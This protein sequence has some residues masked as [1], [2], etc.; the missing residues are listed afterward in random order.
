MILS[1]FVL[2]YFKIHTVEHCIRSAVNPVAE[3]NQTTMLADNFVD[4][5]MI[6]PHNNIMYFRMGGGICTRERPD[7]VRK[8]FSLAFVATAAATAP[9][10]GEPD[11][12]ARMNAGIKT[13]A[14]LVSKQIAKAAESTWLTPY[15]VAMTEE[16]H[17]SIDF[18]L[19][20][21]ACRID[22][23]NSDFIPKVVK[24][25]DIVVAD[26]PIF[27]YSCIG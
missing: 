8:S 9:V 16:K 7:T 17:T 6:V 20:T 10:H 24:K 27:F 4:L 2:T 1:A 18:R 13:L 12:P 22:N 15:P 23:R 14:E 5:K 25:L 21:S 26:K 11:S 3:H 19:N